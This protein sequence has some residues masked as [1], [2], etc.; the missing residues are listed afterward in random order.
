MPG[1]SLLSQRPN[2]APLAVQDA[3]S[4]LFANGQ[5]RRAIFFPF[6]VVRFFLV[7]HHSR[8]DYGTTPA[9]QKTYGRFLGTIFFGGRNAPEDTDRQ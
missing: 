8:R 5:G 2:L 3:S 9:K 1:I 7:L 4:E 6:R